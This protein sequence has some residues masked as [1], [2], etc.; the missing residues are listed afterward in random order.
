MTKMPTIALERYV[1]V[2]NDSDSSIKGYYVSL[3]WFR[4]AFRNEK[5]AISGMYQTRAKTTVVNNQ[6]SVSRHITNILFP[7]DIAYVYNVN[8][9]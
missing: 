6:A 9:E 4:R 8:W 3:Q 2:N 5:K 7:C 1:H